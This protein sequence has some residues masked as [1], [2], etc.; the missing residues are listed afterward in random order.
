[1][2]TG[3]SIT[4]AQLRRL[5]IAAGGNFHGPHI[6]TGTMRESRLLPFLRLLLTES[7]TRILDKADEVTK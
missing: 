2:K 3:R 7:S 6:E 1:M 5:W 4:D